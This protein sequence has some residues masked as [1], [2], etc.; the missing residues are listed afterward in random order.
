MIPLYMPG[1]DE[2]TFSG[3]VSLLIYQFTCLFCATLGLSACDFFIAI[4]IVS[5]LIFSK[6][7]SLEIAQID[8]D[9]LEK[10]STPIVRGRF[11]NILLMHQEMIA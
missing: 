5:T 10:N 8:S 3:Y 2:T 7:I 9:V 1:I 11:R 6:I 4:M